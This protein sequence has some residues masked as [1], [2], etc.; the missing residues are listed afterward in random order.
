V[1]VSID[2]GDAARAAASRNDGALAILVEGIHFE[3]EPM[4]YY[5]VYL[6]L[7]P[8]EEPDFQSVHYAGN[9]SSPASRRV[10]QGAQEKW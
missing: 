1:R 5:E 8:K 9:L 3:K 10:G 4:I 6:D 7:P 2:L